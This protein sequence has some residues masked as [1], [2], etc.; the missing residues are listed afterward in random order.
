MEKKQDAEKKGSKFRNLKS[1][2]LHRKSTRIVTRELV[3]YILRDENLDPSVSIGDA[4]IHAASFLNV[5]LFQTDISIKITIV[6][7]TTRHIFSDCEKSFQRLKLIIDL[8]QQ[9]EHQVVI[10]EM[11]NIFV[12]ASTTNMVSEFFSLDSFSL[13]SRI[14]QVQTKSCI[15]FI[16]ELLFCQ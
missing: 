3:S 15:L 7:I 5:F 10:D 13:H 11:S 14:S 9:H 6:H 16:N 1:K 4:A 12:I 2:I 8:N